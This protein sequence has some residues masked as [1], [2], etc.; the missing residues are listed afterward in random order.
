[1]S[2]NTE[3]ASSAIAFAPKAHKQKKRRD[4]AGDKAA[5]ADHAS[6]A[7]HSVAGTRIVSV[8]TA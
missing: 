4:R 5:E 2:F 8:G 1:M 7:T 3:A 6:E